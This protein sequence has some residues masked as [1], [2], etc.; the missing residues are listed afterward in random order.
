MYD[1]N[2]IAV[3]G[4]RQT[5]EPA[6]P[7]EPLKPPTYPD[8]DGTGKYVIYQNGDVKDTVLDTHQ[9]QANRI[10]PG[11]DKSG[12]IPDHV[13]KVGEDTVYL[14]TVGHRLADA[15]IRFSNQAATVE[16]VLNAVPKDYTPV[17]KL[18]PTALLF[19]MWDSRKTW[20][21]IGRIFNSEIRAHN[22]IEVPAAGQYISSVPRPEGEV[23]KDLSA[24][25]MLDCP[26]TGLGGVIVK[27]EITRAARLNLR[28]IRTLHGANADETEKLQ[29]YV[30]GLGLFALTYPVNFDLR[31]DCNLVATKTEA[32]TLAE[33]G[34]RSPITLTHTDAVAF[35]NEAAKKF[36]VGPTLEFIYDPNA[37]TRSAS[38]K[39]EV[40]ET[41]EKTKKVGKAKAA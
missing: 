39:A 7:D 31:E 41:R 37:A 25:G 40:K 14:T 22:V 27:G 5:L 28:G 8:A 26:Y 21:K 32:F 15:V 9:S 23:T 35:A 10:Q 3:I 18:S 6:F 33:D 13:V 4:V 20:V 2:K 17:A 24:E 19:G 11:F 12:L 38:G 1:I 29:Q 30:L 16:E 34:T 36:G